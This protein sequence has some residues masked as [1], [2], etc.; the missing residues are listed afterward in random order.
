[1]QVYSLTIETMQWREHTSFVDGESPSPRSG[2]TAL[3]LPGDRYLLVYGGGLPENDTFYGT[4][5][6]LDTHSWT[7]ST[8]TLKAGF[9]PSNMPAYCAMT[10]S[11]KSE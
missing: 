3:A 4:L 11:S 2:H 1:M 5:S 6:V 8:P 7:W 9:T 10:G